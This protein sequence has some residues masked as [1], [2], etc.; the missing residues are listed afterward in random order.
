MVLNVFCTIFFSL[1]VNGLLCSRMSLSLDPV[2]SFLPLLPSING[3][4]RRTTGNVCL[5]L[6]A[7]L[8]KT[9]WTS[10]INQRSDRVPET[11]FTFCPN[12]C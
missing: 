6:P 5:A 8:L 12:M 4:E 9:M 2:K 11:K 10:H 3:P 1:K 7:A